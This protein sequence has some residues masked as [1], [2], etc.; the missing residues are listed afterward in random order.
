LAHGARFQHQL[1][2]FRNGHKVTRDLRMRYSDRPSLFNLLLEDGYY[3]SVR[4]Q[5]IPE[6]GGDKTG[7]EC[8][9]GRQRVV[10]RL[11]ID[12]GDA[13]GAPHDVG[14]IHCF[15]RGDHY[16]FSNLEFHGQVRQYFRA[17][18][19]TI[20]GFRRVA[21]HHRH[22]LVSRRVK[23][24]FRLVGI[25]NGCYPGTIGDVGHIRKYARAVAADQNLPFNL[26]QSA[27]R[28]VDK[29]D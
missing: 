18:D 24:Y 29:Y 27:F 10:E 21:L 3:R 12:L 7:L 2:R 26:E 19:I 6:T 28:L 14:W 17:Q 8:T 5:Y 1:T 20:D 13:L 11:H 22:M 4:P 23:N 16:E 15:V 25:E 9:T